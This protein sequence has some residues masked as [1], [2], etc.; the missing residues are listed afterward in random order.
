[1]PDMY[2]VRSKFGDWLIK[3]GDSTLY[4]KF[5]N[6]AEALNY[7]EYLKE[8]PRIEYEKTCYRRGL[9]PP[10][11]PMPAIIYDAQIGE[12]YQSVFERSRNTCDGYV[13]LPH[14]YPTWIARL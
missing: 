7:L 11:H 8:K 6:K 10:R 1:M 14:I 12:D 9:L 4:S 13:V 5:W 2:V 3:R